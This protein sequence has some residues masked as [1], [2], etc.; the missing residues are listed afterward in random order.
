[1]ARNTEYQFVKTDISAL[2]TYLIYEYERM[3]GIT[4]QPAAPEKLFIKWIA[5]IITQERVMNNYT[6]NQNIPSRAEGSNLDALGEL[7]YAEK[8][9]EAAPAYCTERFYISEPQESVIF[10]PKGTRVSDVSSTLIWETTQN[11]GVPI[12][13][14]YVDVRVKCQTVGVTGNDYAPGQLS[15][16]VDLFDYYERCENITTSDGGS[17]A[18][19][20]DEYYELL[21]SSMDAYSCAGAKGGYIYFAKKTS[22]QIADVVVNSPTPGYVNIFVLMDDGTIASEEVKNAVY[23]SCDAD[24]VRAFT[25]F[26]NVCDPEIVPYDIELTYYLPG[27]SARSPS[28]IRDAAEKAVQ[29]YIAWQSGKLGRD[30]NP[31]HLT[32]LLMNAGV[33]RVSIA[34]PVFADLRDGSS[35]KVPQIARLN[36][37]RL[38]NG[39]VEDD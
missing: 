7:F 9:P 39:G 2:E 11:A 30:I 8:R 20:D 23:A 13:M 22:T 26:V 6:G 29:D 21:R 19:D 24:E 1:M 37:M 4:V 17:D 5:S 3:T 27:Q 32:G 18:P 25:D 35:G 34:S 33:K 15:K 36:N 16:L 12:G 10:I 38:I 28:D 31:S 14:D